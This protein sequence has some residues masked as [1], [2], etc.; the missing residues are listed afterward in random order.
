M[1]GGGDPTS[2]KE[3]MNS[4]EVNKWMIT[5]QE[6]LELLHKNKTC[7]LAELPKGKKTIGCK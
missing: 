4:K 3:A 5:M 1:I 7:A 6:E 2:C